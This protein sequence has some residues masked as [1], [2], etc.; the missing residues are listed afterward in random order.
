MYN[1]IQQPE[2]REK[3]EKKMSLISV[4]IVFGLRLKS[5]IV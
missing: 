5:H 3:L 2:K 4:R 1:L